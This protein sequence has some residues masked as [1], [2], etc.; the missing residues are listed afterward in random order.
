VDGFSP[1]VS[2]LAFLSGGCF[3]FYYAWRS[4]DAPTATPMMRDEDLAEAA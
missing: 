1:V 4:H 3:G 2:L